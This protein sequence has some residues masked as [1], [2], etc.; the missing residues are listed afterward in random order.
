MMAIRK[1]YGPGE[2]TMDKKFFRS[3]GARYPEFR[4][5]STV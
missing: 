5:M 4:V 1:I 3:F 2:L